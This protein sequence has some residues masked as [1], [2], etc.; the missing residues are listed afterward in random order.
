MVCLGLAAS[1]VGCASSAEA[2]P[3]EVAGNVEIFSWWT[4]GGELDALESVLAL[5]QAHYPR[6]T[7]TNATVEPADQAREVLRRRINQGLPP[8]TF[9]ANT[10]ADLLNN[11]VRTNGKDYAESKVES[12]EDI[13]LEAGWID[14]FDPDV[15]AAASFKG[16]LW[17]LPVNVHRIN[18]LVIRKDLFEDFGLAVPRTIPELYALCERIENDAAIQQ[19]A[20]DAEGIACLGLGNRWNW[21]LSQMTFEMIL[22][23][24]MGAGAYEQFWTGRMSGDIEDVVAAM[25]VALHLYCGGTDTSDCQATSYFNS[26]VDDI[27]WDAG[28][29]KV[30]EKRAMMAAMGDWAKGLLESHGQVPGVDFDI[31]PFPGS[32]EAFVFTSDTFPLPKGALNREGALALLHTFASAEAQVAFNQLKGSIPSRRIDELDMGDFDPVA[33]ATLS[34]FRKGRKVLALSGLLASNVMPTLAAELTASMQYGSIEI[35]RNYVAANY[36]SITPR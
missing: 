24:L 1:C 33:L 21:P 26:D 27:D 5:H 14:A 29:L 17:A 20:P 8:D 15:L 13:A 12:L 28:V 19:E 22:P 25:E 18:S 34:D 23:G 30:A 7:V 4:S 3:S 11:W 31:V 6:A 35:V 16:K 36:D 2:D 10:G 32:E 9:Q